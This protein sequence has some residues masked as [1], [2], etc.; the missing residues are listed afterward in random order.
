[1]VALDVPHGFAFSDDA[2]LDERLAALEDLGAPYIIAHPYWSGFN[3][4]DL[5]PLKG[6]IG[7]E[8]YNEV[9]AGA[10]RAE[11]SVHWDDLLQE[12]RMLPGVAVDDVHGRASFGGWVMMKLPELTKEAVLAGLRSGSFYATC[13][14]VIEDCRA[15]DGVL[16]VRCSPA[17]KLRF[18]AGAS[19]G[20]VVERP[21]DGELTEAAFE[22]KDDMPYV[23]VE[24]VGE[25]GRKAWTNPLIP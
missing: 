13:G 15:S 23:R 20:R 18:L 2:P 19:R 25:D 17:R 7:V 9:C 6:A 16:R 22:L 14:P 1:M 21:E 3:V 5:R 10:G 24:V 12:G 11:S 8:V 4:H